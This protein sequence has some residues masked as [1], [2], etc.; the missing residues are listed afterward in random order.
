MAVRFYTWQC[1]FTRGSAILHVAVRFCAWQCDFTRGSAILRMAVL[2]RA[3]SAAEDG[4]SGKSTFLSVLL[5][6]VRVINLRICVIN[7]R[8]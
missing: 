7:L 8:H 3:V 4:A 5:R 1:D 6:E 2:L